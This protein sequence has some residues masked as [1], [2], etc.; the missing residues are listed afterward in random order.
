MERTRQELFGLLIFTWDSCDI[1][2]TDL[3]QFYNIEFPYDSMKK[4]NRMD[5][6]LDMDG[7][8]SITTRE[9][10][11]EEVWKDY[12]CAIPEF[13]ER[14]KAKFGGRNIEKG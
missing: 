7:K 2:D 9:E 13:M 1:I 14:V 3:I 12:V 8:L 4:Y 10:E 5:A 11:C 6:S